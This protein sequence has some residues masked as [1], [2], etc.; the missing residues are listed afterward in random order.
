MP[1]LGLEPSIEMEPMALPSLAV[2]FALKS[3]DEKL[4]A[5]GSTALF[6]IEPE[7]VGALYSAAMTLTS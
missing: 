4:T 1:K 2:Y 5:A 6:E 7:N 3:L